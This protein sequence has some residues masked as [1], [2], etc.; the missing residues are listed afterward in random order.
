MTLKEKLLLIHSIVAGLLSL[1][2]FLLV[3]FLLNPQAMVYQRLSDA[4]FFSGGITLGFATLFWIAHSG[5][6]DVLA[7][8]FSTFMKGLS[9]THFEKRYND[10]Y[11]YQQQKKEK[12]KESYF[13]FY[14]YLILGSVLIVLAIVF[15]IL[16]L[17][18]I[19]A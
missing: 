11:D 15:M 4:F 18:A 3:F 2:I 10:F 12:R 13:S 7:Y 19:A 17:Q 1:V 9:P 8:G 5:T 6:F 16:N 14:P